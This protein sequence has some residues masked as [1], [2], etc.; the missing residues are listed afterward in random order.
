M[1][2]PEEQLVPETPTPILVYNRIDANRRKTRLLLASFALALLPV[3]A[4]SS[5]LIA[6]WILTYLDWARPAALASLQAQVDAVHPTDWTSDL[7]LGLPTPLMWLLTGALLVSMAIVALALVATTAFLIYR[8]GSRM[9]SPTSGITTS[10]STR[11]RL[12]RFV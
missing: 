1:T 2:Q 12:P 11:R 10:A 6:P 9:S 5:A 3:V 8:Y 4:A 7:L